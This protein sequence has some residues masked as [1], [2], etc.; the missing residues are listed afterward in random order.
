MDTGDEQ[1]IYAF[2]F[3]HLSQCMEILGRAHEATLPTRLSLFGRPS[4]HL[5]SCTYPDTNCELAQSP[6]PQAIYFSC[7]R[8]VL[9]PKLEGKSPVLMSFPEGAPGL[10][11]LK[12]NA[13]HVRGRR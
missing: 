1:G 7:S 6:S 4:G 10:T 13:H 3:E 8:L 5:P 12:Y 9:I 2:L 11:P